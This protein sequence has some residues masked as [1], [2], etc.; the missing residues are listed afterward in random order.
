M[1]DMDMALVYLLREHDLPAE[2]RI[3]PVKIEIKDPVWDFAAGCFGGSA[4][5][6]VGHPFDTVKIRL[7]TQ[8]ALHPVYSGT[9]DCFKQI[10]QKESIMG[11]YK[12]MSSPLASVAFIN[13][14]GFGIYGNMIRCFDD[15]DS[16]RSHFLAGMAAGAVQSA[17][18]SPMELTKTR[19]QIQGQGKPAWFY[20]RY[21]WKRQAVYRNPVDCAIKLTRA[22]GLRRGFFK[23]FWPTLLRETP[24]CGVYFTAYEV[25]C[26]ALGGGNSDKV[27]PLGVLL[28]GGLSGM[29][30][31]TVTYPID[32]VKSR[33]QADGVTART[34]TGVMHCIFYSY[35][36]EG[37]RMF[38]RGYVATM[39][40]AFP[41][42]AATLAV[43]TWFLRVARK[44]DR[45]AEGSSDFEVLLA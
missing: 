18:L 20:Y 42:N 33:Y 37:A 2:F 9:W 23:G 7:Q 5:V 8:H 11:L 38:W 4:G 39:I 22:D 34:Y 1:R 6:L 45:R 21:A 30:S 40:R 12:G 27:G 26:R 25:M 24:G 3:Q 35:R 41:V 14:I 43:A 29:V 10:I 16:L 15:P 13:A 36:T 31:W 17:I 19:M 28:A 32:V 44:K